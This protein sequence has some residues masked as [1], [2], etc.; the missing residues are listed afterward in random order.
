MNTDYSYC[1]GVTLLNP[2]ELQ[3]LFTRSTRYT[4]A[5]GMAGIQSGNR[6]MQ[7]L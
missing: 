5:M 3:T 7:V 1:S 2:Q 6:Q 4:F